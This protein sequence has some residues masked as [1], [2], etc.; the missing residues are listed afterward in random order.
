MSSG[1]SSTSNTVEGAHVFQVLFLFK[2]EVDDIFSFTSFRLRNTV[3][4]IV[5]YLK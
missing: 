1:C 5:V 2:A 3:C 4:G